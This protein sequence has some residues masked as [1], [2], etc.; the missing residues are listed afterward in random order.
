[1]TILPALHL[2][3][4]LTDI[5]LIVI[6]IY[7]QPKALLNRLCAL[8]VG[9][10][11]IWSLGYG[12]CH[13]A[14][15]ANA[16]M[17]WVN[18]SAVG[19][20]SFSV[21]S[22]YFYLALTKKEKA[23]KNKVMLFSLLAIIAYFFY[24]QL[25][26][27][28]VGEVI[29]KPYG[30]AGVWTISAYSYSFFYYY[31]I[32][33][34]LCIYL[35]LDFRHKA[36]SAH[37]KLQS[38]VLSAT[39]VF[40]LV[41]GSTTDIILPIIGVTN[42]PQVADLL[43]TIWGLGI[44]FS[45]T[46]YG[47]MRLTPLTASD[48]I[49]DTMADSLLLVNVSGKITMANRATFDLLGTKESELNGSDF[50]TVVV[51]NKSAEELLEETEQAGKILNRELCYISKKGNS[52]PVLVSTSA[53]LDQTKDLI[54]YTVL[55]RDMT[56]RRR[57]EIAIR[58][59]REL[60][61]GTLDSTTNM[62][63]VINS[64][65]RVILVNNAFC[66]FFCMKKEDTEGKSIGTIIP[67]TDVLEGISRV[68]LNRETYINIEFKYRIGNHERVLVSKASTMRKG[69]VLLIITDVTEERARQAKLSVNERLVSVGE[70][71]AGIAHELNNPL[72]SITM[73]SQMLVKDD[74]PS[75]DKEDLQ[76]IHAEAKRAAAIVKNLLTF[77]RKHAPERQP[78]Q[79]NR[80]LED[81][82]K[83]R[84][85]EHK[86][87]NI[88]VDAR[89]DDNLPEIKVDYSQMQQVFL[90]LVLNAEQAMI[91]S[92]HQGRLSVTT[93]R[94]NGHIK[95][96][97]RDDGPG[98]SEENKKKLFTPFFTTK[99]VGKGT[100]LGLSISYGIVTNHGGRIYAESEP[101][102]GA[103]FVVELPVNGN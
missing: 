39:A 28:L 61:E 96:S 55:A 2:I 68:L 65:N 14:Y 82:L 21:A 15:S 70:M 74:M 47:L 32:M 60:V 26:G 27:N 83:L 80:V 18:V 19:W 79:L 9:T 50:N 90:N 66:S 41:L 1:M 31:L 85:Y 13:T 11:A 20:S 44:V 92:H 23:I 25:A 22:F 99:E 54:G 81:V 94:V 35:T 63:L 71:A 98:I 8:V 37:E 5:C 12:F 40:G 76:T 100:G 64:D 101:G 6:V 91:E 38:K 42:F 34:V 51:E 62:V 29:E 46:R 53:I 17:F 75:E 24:E 33:A 56:E 95:A 69:N 78:A 86:V 49:F 89:L 103:T 30:W 73:L 58:E 16:A 67:V 72:T 45:V 52:I 87:N 88:Q 93:E 59:Q 36:Q 77:A 7:K 43:V 97:V 10:F 102:K 3:A 4:F 48:Q 84:S 57:A